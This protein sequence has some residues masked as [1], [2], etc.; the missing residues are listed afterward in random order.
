V[1]WTHSRS[2]AGQQGIS[3]PV[4]LLTGLLTGLFSHL[5]YR[6]VKGVRGLGIRTLTFDTKTSLYVEDRGIQVPIPLEDVKIGGTQFC[7]QLHCPSNGSINYTVR[8]D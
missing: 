1:I 7:D 4:S 3:N 2:L 8:S 5:Y 6:T